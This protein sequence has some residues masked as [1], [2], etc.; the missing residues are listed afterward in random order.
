MKRSRN[1]VI[2][3]TRLPRVGKNKTRLIPALG[4]EGATQMHDRLAR[5]AIGAAA[6]FAR[7]N[8]AHLTVYLEGGTP[9]EGQDWLGPCDCREQSKGDLGQRM[10]HACDSAFSE[11]ATKIVVIGTD[12]PSITAATLQQAF[13]SLDDKD[14]VYGPAKDGG[15]YLVG[16]KTRPTHIFRN[17]EWGISTVLEQSLK[18]AN[19]ENLS[20]TQLPPLHDVDLPEDLDAGI[21]AIALSESLSIIIPTHNEAQNIANLIAK[22]RS[23]NPSEIII[24]DGGSTDKT[25]QIAARAGAN[26]I[27][28]RGS[29]SHQMN[30]AAK[31]ATGAY[32]LFLHADTTP[33]DNFPRIIS[34]ALSRANVAA[35]AFAFKLDHLL[36]AAPLIEALVALRCKLFRKPYG[37]QGLFL[38]KTLFEK[39]NGFPN[40]RC[41][42]DLAITKRL[43]RFGTI[44]TVPAP[45]VTS[46]RRWRKGGV[47]RTFI[48]H[49]FM[50]GAYTL[51]VPASWIAKLR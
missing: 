29:R 46:S 39:V 28:T 8:S 45:A 23:E 24:A 40:Q 13:L 26:V 11:G 43:Q 12:C 17:I 34:E 15:Y 10:Q 4:A 2:V 7:E 14:L 20:V 27:E 48:R 25:A 22:L 16:M 3:M 30:E 1:T 5:H 47:V 31:T 9:I 38:R 35:G 51:R 42:E 41:L 6:A 44:V 19:K 37:D 32:L 50:L 18:A 49:Q 36:P 33:P 21:A